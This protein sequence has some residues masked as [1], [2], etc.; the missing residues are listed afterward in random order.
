M[1]ILP[2][3][4]L[5]CF[6]AITFSCASN[7]VFWYQMPSITTQTSPL[8]N[9]ALPVGNGR[10]GGLIAGGAAHERIVLNEDSLWTG[11]ANP[12]G[13][14]GTMGAY[15]ML[16]GAYINLPGH[17]NFSDYRR[18]LDIGDSLAHV[19]YS[20]NGVKFSREYFCSHADDVLVVASHR[21]T[22][23]AATAAALNFDDSHG[24]QT[25]ADEKSP[26]R[27]GRAEQW[28]EIRRAIARAQ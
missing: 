16:G 13:A 15:Q 3:V 5:L 11:G 14:D 19:S 22:S 4:A 24:A 28:L 10:I 27:C 6:G 8:I 18:D 2:L 25:V 23:R 7:L 17:E 9:S 1:K 26:H 12:S 21:R 20:V